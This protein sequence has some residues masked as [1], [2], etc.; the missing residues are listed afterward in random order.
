MRKC[1]GFG[2]GPEQSFQVVYPARE[3]GKLRPQLLQLGGL[4]AVI[5]AEVAGAY[6]TRKSK[7]RKEERR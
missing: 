7:L 3:L 6:N 1:S 5:H 4:V 2:S